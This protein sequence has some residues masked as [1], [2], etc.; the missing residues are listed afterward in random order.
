MLICN[1]KHFPG[2]RCVLFRAGKSDLSVRNVSA[3]FRIVVRLAH[4]FGLLEFF[5]F[6]KILR[7]CAC[8]LKFQRF[9][10]LACIA[11]IS[12]CFIYFRTT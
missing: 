7:F 4:I 1:S 8:S 12:V 5:D 9:Q 3:R 10:K 11:H 6:Q 2:F